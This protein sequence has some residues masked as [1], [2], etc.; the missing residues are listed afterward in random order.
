PG[1]TLPLIM[2][3]TGERR[4]ANSPAHSPFADSP[5]RRAFYP[6]DPHDT[7]R[8]F[9]SSPF[10]A[11]PVAHQHEGSGYMGCLPDSTERSG[12]GANGEQAGPF[13][14]SPGPVSDLFDALDL[15]IRHPE[16]QCFCKIGSCLAPK[17]YCYGDRIVR[18]VL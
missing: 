1:K 9:A 16:A 4:M 7:V 2:A 8:A 18:H 14:R 17:G 3:D 15:T 11:S 12:E 5:I 6:P 10:A 13:A